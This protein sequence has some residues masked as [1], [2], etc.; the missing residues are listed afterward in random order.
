MFFCSTAADFLWRLF[1]SGA[2]QHGLSISMCIHEEEWSEH[3]LSKTSWPWLF[4]VFLGDPAIFANQY[5]MVHVIEVLLTL[6][7][8]KNSHG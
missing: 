1:A 3:H 6:P 4:A 8:K 7:S 2:E 5:R